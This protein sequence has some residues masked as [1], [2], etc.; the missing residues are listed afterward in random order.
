MPVDA[1]KRYYPYDALTVFEDN[2][3]ETATANLANILEMGDGRIDAVAVFDVSAVDIANGDESYQILVQ[4]SND[5]GFASGIENLAIIDLGAAAARLGGADVASLIG[6]H[7]AHFAN[8]MNG[9]EYKYVRARLVIA[10]TTP[11]ITLTAW[12]SMRTE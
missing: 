5:A 4:G 7:E 3:T 10:G 2:A 1:A 8:A 9:V 12:V 11:S 6:R